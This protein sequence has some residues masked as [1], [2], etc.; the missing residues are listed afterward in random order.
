MT[1]YSIEVVLHA[2]I[3]I[4]K[5]DGEIDESNADGLFK[6]L[7]KK[8][9]PLEGRNVIFFLKDLRY[10]NSKGIGHFADIHAK[11]DGTGWRMIFAELTETIQDTLDIV[12]MLEFVDA[13]ETLKEA[14]SKLS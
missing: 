11:L 14:I 3:L 13:E 5:I 2:W 6:E 7:H 9:D 10:T 1:P 8:I 4:V 12:G